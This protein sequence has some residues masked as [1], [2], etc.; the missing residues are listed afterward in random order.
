MLPYRAIALAL[1]IALPIGSALAEPAF[2]FHKPLVD[3]ATFDGEFG[4]CIEL[5][6]G[7]S[8]QRTQIH[9]PNPHA[10]A[11]GGFFGGIMASRERRAMVL[12]VMRTCMADK[13]YQRIAA[14]KEV[15]REL[16]P[17]KDDEKAARLFDLA[18]ASAPVGEVLPR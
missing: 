5:A 13:G 6:S 17:L 15:L 14:S 9:S 18:T 8:V 7:A 2:Y 11:I 12:S 1:A 16:S 4:S 10:A 3:R